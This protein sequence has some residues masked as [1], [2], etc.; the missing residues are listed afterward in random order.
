MTPSGCR[1]STKLCLTSALRGR[2]IVIKY[3]GAT[4]A[5]AELRA[6]VFRDLALLACVGVQPVVVHG[7]GLK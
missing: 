3:G 2:R 5:H 4:M 6:A 1:C 7:G